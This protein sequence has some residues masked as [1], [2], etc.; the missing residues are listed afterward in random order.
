MDSSLILHIYTMQYMYI[1]SNIDDMGHST[2]QQLSW[3]YIVEP[4][5]Y[6]IFGLC[7]ANLSYLQPF[8]ANCNHLSPCV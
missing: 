4:L 5:I 6:G 7:W 3:F 8:V 2:Q 1:T